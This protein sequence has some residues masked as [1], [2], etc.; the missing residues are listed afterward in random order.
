MQRSEAVVIFMRNSHLLQLS[1]TMRTYV[2]LFLLPAWSD[3]ARSPLREFSAAILPAT[4]CRH[5]FEPQPA[6]ELSKR[7]LVMRSGLQVHKFI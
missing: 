4:L 7:N 1:V 3:L 2:C 5:N 6:M